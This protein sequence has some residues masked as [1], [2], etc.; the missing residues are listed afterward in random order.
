MTGDNGYDNDNNYYDNDIE[1]SLLFGVQYL[2][3]AASCFTHPL[4]TICVGL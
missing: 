4:F 1:Y 3:K 2:E